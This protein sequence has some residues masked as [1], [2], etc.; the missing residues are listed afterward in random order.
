MGAPTSRTK[1]T[2]FRKPS[3]PYP[4]CIQHWTVGEGGMTFDVGF[5][6]RLLYFANTGP[7]F[8][9]RLSLQRSSRAKLRSKRDDGNGEDDEDEK[10]DEDEATK[11]RPMRVGQRERGGRRKGRETIDENE[12]DHVEI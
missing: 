8:E 7:R 10:D 11:T 6:W 1:A 9:S 4:K 3:Q 12:H 5:C 2:F